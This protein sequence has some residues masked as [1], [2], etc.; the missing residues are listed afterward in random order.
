VSPRGS[1]ATPASSWTTWPEPASPTVAR[2]S[3]RPTPPAVSAQSACASSS[4]PESHLPGGAGRHR[5]ACATCPLRADCATVPPGGPSPSPR[6]TPIADAHAAD[7]DWVDDSRSTGP[8]LERTLGHMRRGR[9]GGPR[10][11]AGG[12]AKLDADFDRLPPQSPAPGSPCSNWPPPTVDG[13]ERMGG[14]DAVR[15]PEEPARTTSCGS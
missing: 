3:R 1:M 11:R 15:T 7:P 2:P 6:R 14:G 12:E 5:S 8:K 4:A 13:H 9:H 10:A